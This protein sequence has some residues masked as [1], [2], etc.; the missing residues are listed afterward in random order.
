LVPKRTTRG[1]KLL[2]E[3]RD[4]TQDWIPMVGLKDSITL[5]NLP[6]QTTWLLVQHS[7]RG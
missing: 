2:V 3:W 5:S 6:I 1:W 4:G 7:S